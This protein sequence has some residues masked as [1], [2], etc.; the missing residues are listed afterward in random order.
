MFEVT[1]HEKLRYEVKPKFHLAQLDTTRLDTFDVSSL[2]I[3]A[4]STL[5]NSTARLARHDELD[6]L[7]MSSSTGLTR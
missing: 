4:V 2:C 7:D 5:S 6:W 3:L 1:K